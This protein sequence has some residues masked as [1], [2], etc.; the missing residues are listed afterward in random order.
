M[1][2]KVFTVESDKYE[3]QGGSFYYSTE[4]NKGF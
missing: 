2:R 1:K 3:I 4:H